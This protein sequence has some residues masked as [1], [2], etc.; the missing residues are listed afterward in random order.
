MAQIKNGIQHKPAA[1]ITINEKWCKKCGICIHFCPNGVFVSDDFG[2]PVA[3]YPEKCIKCMLCA[4]R[5]PDFAVD[6]S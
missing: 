5:C 2:L 1:E 3:K 4:V 6:V